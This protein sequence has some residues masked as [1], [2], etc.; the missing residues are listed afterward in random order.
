VR[1][2]SAVAG[3]V[4]AAGPGAAALVLARRQGET[5]GHAWAAYNLGG[6][7]GVVWVDVSAGAE[8]E[9]SELPPEVAASDAQAVVIDPAGQ[10]ID[11][12]GR[13]VMD[14]ALPP[15]AQS[16]STTHAVLDAAT[17]RRFG[18]LGLEVEP[19]QRFLITGIGDVAAKLVLAEAPGFKIVTDHAN[20]WRTADGRLHLSYPKLTPGEP[21]PKLGSYL[22]G[23]IVV[24]PM[25][26][27]PGE[28]RQDPEETLA[29]LERVQRMLDARDEP[30]A[31]PMSLAALLP[32]QDGWTV[33]ELGE[34]AV[35][36]PTPIRWGRSY[37][38]P[39]PGVPALGLSALL[40]DAADRLPLGS[41]QASES[42]SREFG[43]AATAEF[44]RDFLGRSDVPAMSV[45]FLA[46]IPDI[47][48]IW[49]YLRFAYAH[50][51]AR[52]TGTILNQGPAP[53]MAKNALAVASRPA[54]DRVLRALRPRTR[55]F[56]N[57][58][59]DGISGNLA[60]VLGKLLEM[61]RKAITPDKPF[62]PGFFDA[63][64]G[65]VPSPREHVTSVLTGRTSEGKVVT[66]KQMVDMDDDRFPT[67]DTDDGRLEIPL[68]PAELRHFT[69][70]DDPFMTREDI[71][72]AVAELSKLSREAYQRALTYRAPL[73]DDVLLESIRRILNNPAVR[74]FT[75]FVHMVLM[76]GLPKVGGGSHRLMSVRDS[77][78][79]ARA[80]GAYALGTP[81]PDSVHRALRSAVD[82]AAGLGG[83]VPPSH[84]PQL[85]ALVEA[86]RGALEVL[87]DP[88]RTP[89]VLPWVSELVAVDG[90]R[91]LLDRVLVVEHWDAGWKPVGVSSRPDQDWQDAWRHAYGLLPEVSGFTHVRRGPV[92][93]EGP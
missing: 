31:A 67:L 63:T 92:P 36:G 70:A 42:S 53:F 49:G 64:I 86:A 65:D 78:E 71:R 82:E 44:L 26:V 79:A 74:G 69:Y 80:L 66:Q 12:A 60:V 34:K 56:L 52:P 38:Q 27:L 3:A 54:L 84:Q 32:A 55:D 16:T 37:V 88:E 35:V 57:L 43:M 25:A 68:V 5:P 85:R 19:R 45:P 83:T 11:P 6:T 62:F 8:G 23:E 24:E 14:G 81:L 28:R 76:A 75:G 9:I 17:G 93:L 47:D 90:S 1:S 22:V 15:F 33:T 10:A 39:T 30:N 46:H 4:A 2:W 73:P 48:D 21:K 59:H 7:D 40:D 61:Y 77:Q 87:A 18:A 51:V 58:H 72:R 50:T 20:L 89:P 29:R 91:V 41:V 13:D